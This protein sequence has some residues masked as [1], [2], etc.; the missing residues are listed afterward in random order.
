MPNDVFYGADS[1]LRVGIQADKDTLPTAWRILEFNR[2]AVNVERQRVERPRLGAARANKL[3]PLKPR[4]GIE[5]FKLDLTIDGCLVS[6]P[7]WLRCLLG[8][9]TTTG[10]SAPY[11]HVWDSGAKTEIYAAIAVR[12]GTDKIHVFK[13]VSLASIGCQAAG[14]NVQDFDIQMAMQAISRTREDS[15][16]TG[17]TTAVPTPAP[18]LKSA[19]LIDGVAADQMVNAA[20]S[21]D[22]NLMDDVYLT[23]GSGHRNVSYLRPGEQ[24]THSGS[25]TIRAFGTT[26]D[27]LGDGASNDT[28]DFSAEL[29]LYGLN[30]AQM[31]KLAHP[32]AQLAQPPLEIGQGVIERSLSWNGHQT[33]S[34]PASR[35]SVLNAVASYAT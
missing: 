3:D 34:A 30:S 13:G 4:L 14:E 11:T 18:I 32:Q 27:A 10:A 23:T 7:G 33:S 24:P 8:A 12:V 6:L 21:W 22:R 2:L 28:T 16:P 25:A 31:I 15:W 19:L 29:R 26:F 9:P 20:F 35:I 17:T 5:R 1:E